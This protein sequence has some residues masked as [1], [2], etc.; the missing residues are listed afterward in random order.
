MAIAHWILQ[1]EPKNANRNA[2][3]LRSDKPYN[4]PA[5]RNDR[6]AANAKLDGGNGRDANAN[7]ID[8]KAV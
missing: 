5:E 4:R 7:A 1:Q 3:R 6:S 8:A 2:N